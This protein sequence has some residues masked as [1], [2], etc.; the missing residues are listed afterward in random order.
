MNTF[1]I[2]TSLSKIQEAENETV[3]VAAA[4]GQWQGDRL[5]QRSFFDYCL[6]W[7]MAPWIH[8]QLSRRAL[9]GLFEPEI[10]KLFYEVHEKVK[11]ENERRNREARRF[12]AAFIEQGIDVIVLKGNLLAHTVYHDTGYKRMND[13]DILIHAADWIRAQDVY[14]SLGY[15]PLGFGWSGEKQKPARFSH[16]GMS[17]ISPDYSCIVGTQWGLKSP[18][19]PYRIQ[20]GELWDTSQDFDFYGLPVRQLSTLNNL[21]HLTLHMGL[22]KCGIRDCMDVYNLLLAEPV[23]RA[24]WDKRVSEVNAVDKSQFTLSVSNWCSGT[25]DPL[26]TDLRSVGNSFIA[27]R[28][29]KREAVYRQ[30]GDIQDSYNDYFQDVEKVVIYFNLFPAFHKKV[31]FYVKILKMIFWP[32]SDMAGKLSDVPHL[33]TWASRFRA[34]ISAPFLVFSLIAQEIGWTFTFLLF[35]KLFVDL[36]F[37]LKN[38]FV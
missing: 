36:L 2:V 22:Y 7:K 3:H 18:T 6:H 26:V 37:S 15:I 30:T 31:I 20:A 21:L 9:D 10:R 25:L 11:N 24:Q 28:L 32:S 4:L 17:Y 5:A 29:K 8:T 23:D 35:V 13:F 19:T 1:R 34:R 16:V 14:V 33:N 38:Y 12:L 27:R